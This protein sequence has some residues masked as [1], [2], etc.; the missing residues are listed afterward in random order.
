MRQ[1]RPPVMLGGSRPKR[2]LTIRATC[3]A[4]TIGVVGT[5][6][7]VDGAG[8]GWA[9]G[10]GSATGCAEGGAS[11]SGLGEAGG[12]STPA[13]PPGGTKFPPTALGGRGTESKPGGT[14]VW[15]NACDPAIAMRNATA[16]PVRHSVEKSRRAVMSLVYRL[17]SGK[18][19]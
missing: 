15:A 17:K 11:C 4:G 5:A 1:C 6:R 13:G 12:A 3:P 10:G 18:F 9:G 16:K 8:A 2:A 14:V 19:K 7:A